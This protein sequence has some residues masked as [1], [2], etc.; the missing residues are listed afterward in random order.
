MLTTIRQNLAAFVLAVTLSFLLWSIAVS[1]QNPDKTDWLPQTLTIRTE[2]LPPGFVIA[3][4][5][6]LPEV[7]VRITTPSDHFVRVRASS[8]K[9]WLDLSGA[10]LGTRQY[11]VLVETE[12][13]RVRIVNWN[14]EQV[15]LAIE[16]LTRKNVSV[17]VSVDA[18][19]PLGFLARE[20]RVVPDVVAVSGPESLVETVTTATVN[21]NLASER[22]PFSADLVPVPRAADGGAVRGVTVTP[23]RVRVEVPIEQQAAYRVIPIVPTVV[24]TPRLG[25]QV[26]GIAVDPTSVTIVGDP[27]AVR[28]LQFAQ[29][30]AVD[31]NGATG[32]IIQSVRVRLPP[33]V[34]LVR[35]QTLTVRLQVAP[36]TGS[37]VMRIA[38]TVINLADTLRATVAPGAIEVLVSGPMPALLTLQPRD[39]RLIVDGARLGPG[40][41]TL[42][43]AVEAPSVLT[44]ERIDPQRV[45]LTVTVRD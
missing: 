18:D 24:G 21:I 38:P 27:A 19:V 40:T 30:E 7:Q 1:Q 35:E 22:E 3:S 23:Q 17:R 5:R 20:P 9:A 14:P 8:F 2:G 31:V 37:Q 41:H 6:S 28:S 42:P 33:G 25:Y 32:D 26:V 29:T 13:R 45:L 43:L 4:P 34:S 11:P 16:P 10:T 12:D 39:I 15:T 44:I 36:L